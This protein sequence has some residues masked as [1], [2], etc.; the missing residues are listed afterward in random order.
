MLGHAAIV[1]WGMY[2]PERI[3]T[4]RELEGMVDTSDEWITSRTGI[5]QRHIAGV[6]ETTSSMGI[7][8]AQRALD[9]IADAPDPI[10]ALAHAP[11]P[12]RAG[13]D[14]RNFIGAVADLRYSNWPA[15]LERA[16]V[17]ASHQRY[18]QCS[19][20]AGLRAPQTWSPWR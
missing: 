20:S 10:A 7:T 8:A 17:C 19:T 9:H 1:G 13:E 14:W 4:N 18:S 2:A 11:A 16:R 3:M 12:P 15:D 6:D 5:K